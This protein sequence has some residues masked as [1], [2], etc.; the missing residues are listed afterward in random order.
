MFLMAWQARVVIPTFRFLLFSGVIVG[1]GAIKRWAKAH[2]TE[3]ETTFFNDNG[4]AQKHR[5]MKHD[6]PRN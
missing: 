1:V 6:A 4:P 5:G 2:P 3:A